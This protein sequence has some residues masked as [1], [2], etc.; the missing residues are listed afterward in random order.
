[1]KIYNKFILLFR[2]FFFSIFSF[3][4]CCSVRRDLLAELLLT[5]SVGFWKFL[6]FWRQVPVGMGDLHGSRYTV[7]SSWQFSY[8]ASLSKI[9]VFFWVG[10]SIRSPF[11]MTKRPFYLQW[12]TLKKWVQKQF[13]D[14]FYAGKISEILRLISSWQVFDTIRLMIPRTFAISDAWFS[15]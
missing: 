2:V 3:L 1:M 7:R 8:L 11:D 9:I 4:L 10:S 5:S 15:K 14:R 6:P 12:E 13:S